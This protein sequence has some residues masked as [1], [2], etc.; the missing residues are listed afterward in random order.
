MFGKKSIAT[1]LS[2]LSLSILVVAQGTDLRVWKDNKGKEHMGSI[3]GANS[4][5]VTIRSDKGFFFKLAL[6]DLSEQDK[7]YVAQWRVKRQK[8]QTSSLQKAPQIQPRALPNKYRSQSQVVQLS[9]KLE[10]AYSSAWPAQVS[11]NTGFQVDRKEYDRKNSR[12]VYQSPNFEFISDEPLSNEIVRSFAWMFEGTHAYCS[13][14]PFNLE[15]TQLQGQRKMRTYLF[16]EYA[17]YLRQGGLP[18]TAGTYHTA[19]DRIL[20]PLQSLGVRKVGSKWVASKVG[21]SKTLIHEITHQLM[22]GPVNTAPWFIEGV[23]EYIST[24]PFEGNRFL[25]SHHQ[26]AIRDY[27]IGNGRENQGGWRI[28]NRTPFPNL[29]YFMSINYLEFQYLPRAYP[30]AAMF[31]YYWAHMDGAG[32]GERLRAYVQALQ[33]GALEVEARE[34]LIDGRKWKEIEKEMK[35]KWGRLSL[36]IEFIK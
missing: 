20:I 21:S 14:L 16:G 5:M 30:F 6:Q 8:A 32:N 17:D 19:N 36:A 27:L 9:K 25:T 7:K 15:R 35:L 28:G 11:I 29:E 22:R 3:L 23:A 26:K 24:I 33:N 31:F 18:R 10:P 2:F 1:I 13:K 4:K 34:L 12:Y